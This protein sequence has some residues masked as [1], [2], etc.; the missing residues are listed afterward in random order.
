MPPAP[1]AVRT[2]GGSHKASWSKKVLLSEDPGAAALDSNDPNYDEIL[3]GEYNLD[4][5]ECGTTFRT[6]RQRAPSYATG[7]VNIEEAK[8]SLPEFQKKLSGILHDYFASKDA[9]AAVDEIKDLD[10]S[11]YHDEL[12]YRTIKIALDHEE[13]CQGLASSLLTLL[14]SAHVVTQSQNQRAFEKLIE[15]WED[16]SI[17]VPN[18]PEQILKFLDCALCDGIVA[19]NFVTRLPENLL[20]KIRDADA[21][22]FIDVYEQLDELKTFK[23]HA[24]A[25]LVDYFASHG[26]GGA[27]EV[28]Q[29]LLAL[30]KPGMHHE[31]V[32]SA[33]QLSFDRDVR[34]RAEV[35]QLLADLRDKRVLTDDDL[36]LGFGR[37]LGSL[38]D[39]TLDC[40]GA[41]DMLSG[42]IVQAVVEELLPPAFLKNSLR[43]R[44]GN[45]VGINCVRHAISVLDSERVWRQRH[46]RHGRFNLAG[47]PCSADDDDL[48]RSNK[49]KVE[50]AALEEEGIKKWKQELRNAIIEYFC[51]ADGDE[52]CRLAAEW[53]M[54]SEQAAIIVKY[55]LIMAMERT[56]EQ[57]LMAA[58]LLCHC[59]LV[60]EEL[61][62]DDIVNGFKL[63]MSNISDVKLDI[64]DAVD[65]LR[66]FRRL[67]IKRGILERTAPEVADADDDAEEAAEQQQQQDDD[68]DQSK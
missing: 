4:I 39:F 45:D 65:M 20:R 12:V 66:A 63:I 47:S 57:C 53:D 68:Q 21:S 11:M 52:F 32:R 38:E 46:E 51:S 33:L 13:S 64:P 28:G 61:S 34:T 7:H 15:V 22:E 27:E 36:T 48:G 59:V 35:I 2:A 23:E 5:Y 43:L 41:P 54:S 9:T 18:A 29:S 62:K 24:K 58:D 14:Y 55:I 50:F 31:F 10:C 49:N 1:K 26:G 67:C 60:R 37:M 8:L 6:V 16:L 19:D 44:T 17:D 56:G 3:D 42:L 40:P 30:E 25:I